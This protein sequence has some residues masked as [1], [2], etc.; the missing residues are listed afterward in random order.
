MPPEAYLPALIF[1]DLEP[2][3]MF[4]PLKLEVTPEMLAAYS[5]VVGVDPLYSRYV[6]PGFAGIIGRWAYLQDHSMPGGGVLLG[7]SIRWVR[8]AEAGRPLEATAVVTDRREANGRRSV[9]F[10]TTIEQDG[11]YVA[12]VQIVAGWPK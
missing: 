3:R 1:D 9:I 4:R 10:E 12:H 2:G 7:Q 6:P 8:P 11:K 5:D